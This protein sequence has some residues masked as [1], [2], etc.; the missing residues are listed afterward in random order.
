MINNKCVKV[1][2]NKIDIANVMFSNELI[3]IVLLIPFFKTSFFDAIPYLSTIC[4]TMLV[5]EAIV[6]FML[7]VLAKRTSKFIKIICLYEIWNYLI[8]PLLGKT[9]P[10]SIFYLCGALAIISISELGFLYDYKKYIKSLTDLFTIMTILNLFL[11]FIYPNGVSFG[12]NEPAVY[13][14]GI[15]TGFSLVILPGMLIALLNDS[16]NKKRRISVKTWI[17]FI[18]GI[19]SLILKWVATGLVEIF[20]VVFLYVIFLKLNNKR[21]INVLNGTT[22]I[23]IIDYLITFS[24]VSSRILDRITVFL[25]KDVTLTGRTYIWKVTRERIKLSPFFGYGKN[26]LVDIYGVDKPAHNQWLSIIIESGY[27]GV[28]IWIIGIFTSLKEL[29]KYRKTAMY[30]IITIFVFAILIACISEIQTYVPFIYFIFELPFLLKNIEDI[31]E[32]TI[33]KII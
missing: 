17:L 11:V 22:I 18:C 28:A 20:V 2:F 3:I 13:L 1:T 9:T 27:I 12:K 6:F 29:I 25:D 19:A 26:N 16:I 31:E 5:I 15:R 23:M 7:S 30:N 24:E 10:P 8:A 4:N 21:F 33:P 32:C 14:F